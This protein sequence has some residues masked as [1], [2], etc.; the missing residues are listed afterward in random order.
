MN[1]QNWKFEIVSTND[2]CPVFSK[3]KKKYFKR[4]VQLFGTANIWIWVNSYWVN[5]IF[6]RFLPPR[7]WGTPASPLLFFK[8]LIYKL[9]KGGWI[10]YWTLKWK[11]DFKRGVLI[12]LIYY[13][14]GPL[15]IKLIAFKHIC[16]FSAFYNLYFLYY[17]YF[18][19]FCFWYRAIP[20]KM[21][22]ISLVH[23]RCSNNKT[24]F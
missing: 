4:K 3:L 14:K 13:V 15:K 10:P 12:F 5:N 20:T 1:Y 11:I 18:W 19:S 8:N 6:A 17:N 23:T 2:W 24:S 9:K 16:V 21:D 22:K 7:S